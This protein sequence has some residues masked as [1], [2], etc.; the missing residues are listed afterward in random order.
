M[1]A[2]VSAPSSY[3]LKVTL[4]YIEPSIWRRLLVPADLTLGWLHYVLQVSMGW[5]NDHM[6]AFRVGKDSYGEP[7]DN[8]KDEWDVAVNDVLK[9]KG[10]KILY[11]YDFGDCWEHEVLLEDKLP[12][13][14]GSSD[15]KC[16]GGQRAC[17]PEDCGGLGG[18]DR[19][20]EI[21]SDPE[22]PEYYELTE[23]FGEG[24]DP[25]LFDQSEVN[26]RLK[27]L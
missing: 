13:E 14:V 24:F 8:F 20:L 26:R 9:R 15:V 4:K 19:F 7:E 3:Q 11:E 18:Y 27:D 22:H 10:S 17:P 6:H 25:E 16:I 2:C 21:R 1:P 5:D 23:W 12:E